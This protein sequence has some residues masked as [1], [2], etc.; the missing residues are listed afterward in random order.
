MQVFVNLFHE[1]VCRNLL[2]GLF[3]YCM[4]VVFD[5]NFLQF[6]ILVKQSLIVYQFLL[7][8]SNIQVEEKQ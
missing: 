7:A 3:D 4:I 6:V 8:G 5:I 2:A 1:L